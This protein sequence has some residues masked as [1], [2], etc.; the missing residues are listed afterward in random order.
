[1]RPGQPCSCGTPPLWDKAGSP[2]SSLPL[3]LPAT[4]TDRMYEFD[5]RI[6]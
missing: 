2:A 3:V 1:M 6:G 4:V 5:M